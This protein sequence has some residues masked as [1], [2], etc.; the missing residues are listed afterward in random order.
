MLGMS[1]EKL[2]NSI[3]NFVGKDYKV[4]NV[5]QS[6]KPGETA[7]GVVAG[8]VLRNPETRGILVCGNGFGIAKDASIGEAITVINCVTVSQ[9]KSGREVNNANILALG[10]K[11]VTESVAM[12]IVD[13]FLNY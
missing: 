4:V 9:A 6:L 11:M 12:D 7:G 5:N 2:F 3:M 13:T 8:L 10:S 1:S